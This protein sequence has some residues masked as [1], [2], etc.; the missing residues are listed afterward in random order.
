LAG[1]SAGTQ[2]QKRG[3]VATESF[4]TFHLTSQS[5]ISAENYFFDGRD[6]SVLLE[7]ILFS[8]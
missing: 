2:L 1:K 6:T 3:P 4:S 7:K 5:V 8:P